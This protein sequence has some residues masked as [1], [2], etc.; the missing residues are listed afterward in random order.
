MFGTRSLRTIICLHMYFII[1]PRCV[2]YHLQ[3]RNAVSHCAKATDGQVWIIHVFKISVYLRPLQNCGQKKVKW[4]KDKQTNCVRLFRSVKVFFRRKKKPFFVWFI[5]LCLKSII[6]INVQY[7]SS[8]II[9]AS[10]NGEPYT[11]RNNLLSNSDLRERF[12]CQPRIN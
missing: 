2:I 7:V 11:T 1:S 5:I 9:K 8:E 6:K 10:D 4:E 12:G 3:R